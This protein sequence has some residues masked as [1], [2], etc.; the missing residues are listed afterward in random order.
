MDLFGNEADARDAYFSPDRKYRYWLS[1]I[2]DG[3]LPFVQFIGLN[4]STANENTDDPTIRRIVSFAKDWGYGG[5]YM[6]NLFG[7]VSPYPDEL[8][9]CDDPIGDNNFWLK[10]VR[11]WC[12]DVV[13]CWGSFEV[14][15]RDKEVTAM[16]PEATC[17]G[18]T[19][20]G[21]PK[22]PLYLSKNTRPV[23][24]K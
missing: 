11:S 14:F 5:F 23:N 24:Y 13:F 17:F 12:R 16:F 19:K 8:M 15:G 22:H 4:P 6:T 2:W 7:F 3:R 1:R 20:G 21:N 18:L 9:T 10:E